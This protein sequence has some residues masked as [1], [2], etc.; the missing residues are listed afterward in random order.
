[1]PG[2]QGSNR[3]TIGYHGIRLYIWVRNDGGVVGGLGPCWGHCFG[4]DDD[5]K[6]IPRGSH[7]IKIRDSRLGYKLGYK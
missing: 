2:C 4:G 7:E 3:D 6:M 5:K 1:M